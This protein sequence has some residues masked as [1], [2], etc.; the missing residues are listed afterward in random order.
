MGTKAKINHI[1][2]VTIE[3]V[4]K[5]FNAY[6][7]NMQR[8]PSIMS[9][10]GRTYDEDLIS[11]LLLK[12]L[13]DDPSAVGSI[14]KKYDDNRKDAGG[15]SNYDIVIESGKC[16]QVAE[17][18][19]RI[20]IFITGH[21]GLGEAFT[22]A[23]ENK[24]RS[25]EHSE[26]TTTYARWMEQRAK[27]DEQL[28]YIFLKPSW[29]QSPHSS[30]RFMPLSYDEL[31]KLF[32]VENRF[33]LELKEHI[34]NHLEVNETM[35]P[36]IVKYSKDILDI[37]KELERRRIEIAKEINKAIH[38][39]FL[40]KLTED[41]SPNRGIWRYYAK[42]LRWWDE[43]YK[44]YFYVEFKIGEDGDFSH[45]C[46]QR[47]LKVYP[48]HNANKLNAFAR[49][50]KETEL[51]LELEYNCYWVY[52]WDIKAEGVPLS[53]E[54]ATSVKKQILDRMKT[55]IDETNR[56]VNAFLQDEQL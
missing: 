34:N 17:N 18:L 35:D 3:R 52:R 55:A 20:D 51:K 40:E 47:V 41:H 50:M 46:V 39:G 15:L 45:V 32:T 16:E 27:E 23:I 22:L 29:N 11:R 42:N 26:Q 24:I 9:V 12:C 1:D 21:N 8:E 13:M 43:H 25:W 30:E 2:A 31:A 5:A 33:I 49:K 7:Q 38:D 53:D 10:L 19:S 4:I 37:A 36:E 14:L 28:Y 44:Y 54:W 6:K 48:K 56:L